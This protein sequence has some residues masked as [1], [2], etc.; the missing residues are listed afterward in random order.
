MNLWSNKSHIGY[1]LKQK[2]TGIL[3]AMTIQNVLGILQ[4]SQT[5]NQFRR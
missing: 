5:S 3:A 2:S 4:I 1:I